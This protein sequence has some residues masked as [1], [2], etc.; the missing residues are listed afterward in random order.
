[1]TIIGTSMTTTA[2]GAK[3]GMPMIMGTMIVATVTKNAAIGIM[4]TIGNGLVDFSVASGFTK[5][6]PIV[7]LEMMEIIILLMTTSALIMD[8]PAARKR[9]FTEAQAA[10]MNIVST[11]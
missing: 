2:T 8:I 5:I 9:S 3:S 6:I 7:S 11:E 1:M 10:E 4:K